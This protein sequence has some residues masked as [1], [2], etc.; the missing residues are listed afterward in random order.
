[1]VAG[2]LAAAGAGADGDGDEGEGPVEL[3]LCDGES[4]WEIRDGAAERSQLQTVQR[5]ARPRVAMPG[6]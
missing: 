4:A 1:M 2:Q 3:A 5:A 6:R